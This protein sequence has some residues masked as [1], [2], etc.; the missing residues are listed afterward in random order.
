MESR[1]SLEVQQVRILKEQSQL[2]PYVQGSVQH[3][4]GAA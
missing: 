2:V 1:P 3:F 4:Q